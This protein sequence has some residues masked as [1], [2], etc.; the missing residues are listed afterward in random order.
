MDSTTL[1]NSV[2]A[3]TGLTSECSHEG[4]VT[5]SPFV[6][7]R[8]SDRPLGVDV[9]DPADVSTSPPTS[10]PGPPG[11]PHPGPVL[12]GSYRIDMDLADQTV[13]G[14]PTIGDV[15]SQVIW[16]AFRS[17]CT[18]TRCVAVATELADNNPQ[19]PSGGG[20]VF[21]FADGHWNSTAGLE[22]SV[23]CDLGGP[24]TV[25]ETMGWTLEPQANGTLRGV[26]TTTVLDGNCG[27][28]DS[29]KGDVYKTTAVF[30]RTGEVPPA[31]VLADPALF[32]PG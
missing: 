8:T 14:R 12:D 7:T 24:S 13:N 2:R 6:A 9:T 26:Q 23:P 31:A 19:V 30:T 27:P 20:E 21:Q 25:N 4:T 28:H 22:P 17:L 29:A 16:W 3:T 32:M 1:K 15:K 5:Q 11:A 18:S 10:S